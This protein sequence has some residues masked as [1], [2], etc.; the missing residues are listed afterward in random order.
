VTIDTQVDARLAERL[1]VG[2]VRSIN[3]LSKFFKDMFA[4]IIIGSPYIL[5]AVILIWLIKKL[6]IDRRRDKKKTER[7]DNNE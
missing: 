7:V 2:F 4:I 3:N 6:F 1:S 5:L